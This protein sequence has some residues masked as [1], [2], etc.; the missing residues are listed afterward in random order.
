MSGMA[1]GDSS[2]AE[3]FLNAYS[4]VEAYLRKAMG[5]VEWQR[6]P[7]LL[8]TAEQRR[9]VFPGEVATLLRI[10]Q[11]RNAIQHARTFGGRPIADP[12]IEIVRVIEQIRE[13]L[14]R[15]PAAATFAT[16]PVLSVRADERLAAVLPRL[17]DEDISQ[18]PVF[19]QGLLIGLCTLEQVAK[20]FATHAEPDGFIV[21]D[22]TF[23]AVITNETPALFRCLGPHG[24]AREAINALEQAHA[25]GAPLAALLVVDHPTR[26]QVGDL[27]GIL[28]PSD[29]PRLLTAA[30]TVVW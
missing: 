3:R 15:P 29:L 21:P 18:V 27:R 20:W 25:E 12:R 9:V 13:R 19:D 26:D 23:G 24:S 14:L 17:R 22:A 11:L 30:T 28:T 6:M 10:A 8:A 16:S 7:E 5:D 4:D 2:R 1:S